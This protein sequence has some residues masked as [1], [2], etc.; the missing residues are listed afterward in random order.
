MIEDKIQY[1]R[2]YKVFEFMVWY[3]HIKAHNR[4]KYFTREINDKPLRDAK[5]LASNDGINWV[6][7][8]YNDNVHDP[9]GL[10]FS[11]HPF[12]PTNEQ[13]E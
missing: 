10:N 7:T 13:M 9:L 11:N 2:G 6:E 8:T 1:P 12:H 5:L 3:D 4:F